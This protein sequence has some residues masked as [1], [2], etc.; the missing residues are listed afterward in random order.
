MSTEKLFSSIT[1]G[2]V[3][4]RN[5]I[6]MAPMISNLATPEGYPSDAHIAYLAER[7]KGGVGLIFTEY[8]YVNRIDARGSL[9]QLGLYSDELI[10]KFRRLTEA[11]KAHGSRIFVQLVHAGRK[12]RRNIIWGNTPIAPSPIPLLDDVREMSLEDIARVK[13]D[14]AE[15]ALRAE[16]SGFDGI[17]IHGAHGYLVA[18]FLSPATNK[19]SDAYRDGVR[20]VVEL[21][22]EMRSRVSIPIGIRLSVTEFDPQG[23]NPQ[24][25]AEIVSRL[26]KEAGLDYIHLSAGRDG[27]IASSMPFYMPRT[28]L[29]EDAKIVR[30]VTKLPLLLV[31]SVIDPEDALRVLE[32]ADMV[33]LG[34]Q[35]LADPAWPAKVARRLPIRPCIRCN[36]LC[37]AITLSEVRC[38]VNPELGWEAF[39]H[40]ERGSGEVS[41]IGGGLMGL[42]AARILALRGFDVTLYEK[43]HRLG[44]QLNLYRDPYK[45]REFGLLVDYYEKT[46][47]MLGVKIVLGVEKRCEEDEDCI[48]AVPEEEPPKM[49][50]IKGGRILIDSNLY[51]YHDYAFELAKYNEVYMT[52]RSLRDLERSRAFL[53]E[54]K[55]TELGVIFIEESG[56]GSKYDLVISEFRREQP[57][58][59]SAIR[60]GYIAGK[61]YGSLNRFGKCIENLKRT[62]MEL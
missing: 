24:M 1:I 55:L 52:R 20:F 30:R 50:E 59:A 10:P 62:K 12:T 13:R 7:A 19:R 57:S 46:L 42:E 28:P 37:R 26:E 41:V 27:P 43:S 53:M 35:L 31:G 48:Y 39:S 32:V 60:R 22:E 54:K 44:G 56:E 38:D 6:A 5:R 16:R 34:R 15:A 21:V 4:I 61:Y 33:V 8:T 49:P 45:A 9:N 29:I 25:V 40:L 36:Q 18:Q 58:I 51:P 2:S 11:V 47:R 14:F 23:L 3:R 17:E